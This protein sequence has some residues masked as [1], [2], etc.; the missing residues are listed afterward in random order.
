MRQPKK[1]KNVFICQQSTFRGVRQQTAITDTSFKLNGDCSPA[2]DK[3]QTQHEGFDLSE[4]WRFF[5]SPAEGQPDR[6]K[7]PKWHLPV[8]SN[9]PVHPR[10]DLERAIYSDLPKAWP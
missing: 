7:T 4:S 8:P 5:R 9:A 6:W 3:N 1:N 2:K 10:L